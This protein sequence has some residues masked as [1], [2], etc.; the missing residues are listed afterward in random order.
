MAVQMP[1]MD[2]KSYYIFDQDDI[3]KNLQ[4]IPRTNTRSQYRMIESSSDVSDFLNVDGDLTIKVKNGDIGL[5]VYGKYM[6]K[7]M[8]RDNSVEILITVYHE[9]VSEFLIQNLC[10]VKQISCYQWGCTCTHWDSLNIC[11]IC[12]K[13]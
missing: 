1:S 4:V 13:S 5:G 12:I 10:K 8:D 11:R 7:T 3:S 9:L 2:R 6:M